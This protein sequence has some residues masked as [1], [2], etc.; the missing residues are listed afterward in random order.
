[1]KI[2]RSMCFRLDQQKLDF[3]DNNTQN[4]EEYAKSK[5]II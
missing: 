2:V 3:A 5:L 1:M 4:D